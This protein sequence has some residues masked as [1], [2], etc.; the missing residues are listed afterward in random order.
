M[1]ASTATSVEAQ[2]R[3]STVFTLPEGE[4]TLDVSPEGTHFDPMP[5]SPFS[6][7]RGHDSV[8]PR[9]RSSISSRTSPKRTRT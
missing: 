3:A 6:H 7:R 5:D 2:A 8:G 9:S 4:L 1:T